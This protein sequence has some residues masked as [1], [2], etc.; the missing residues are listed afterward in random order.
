M[1]K[2]IETMISFAP[3]GSQQVF[4]AGETIFHKDESGK[5]MYGVISGEVEMSLD[6]KVIEIITPGDVFGEG[7]LINPEHKRYSTA[8]AKT[9]CQLISFDRQHFLFAVQETPLFALEV[10]KSY[11]ERFRHLKQEFVKLS[12]NS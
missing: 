12:Q 4:Q 10:L 8:I 7:A 2:P 6:G 5:L 9:D 1:L 3:Q 11:S